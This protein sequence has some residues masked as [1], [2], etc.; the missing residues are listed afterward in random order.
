MLYGTCEEPYGCGGRIHR[1]WWLIGVHDP[2]IDQLVA[3]TPEPGE[4]HAKLPLALGL[5]PAA[6]VP[7]PIRIS[8]D[9]SAMAVGLRQ[10]RAVSRGKE[11]ARV[12]VSPRSK[13]LFVAVDGTAPRQ[14][15]YQLLAWYELP[16]PRVLIAHARACADPSTDACRDSLFALAAS[17]E[18]IDRRFARDAIQSLPVDAKLLRVAVAAVDARSPAAGVVLHVLAYADSG[19]LPSR[20][21]LVDFATKPGDAEERAHALMVL[22]RRKD[23][24]D[25]D[26]RRIAAVLAEPPAPGW[27]GPVLDGRI[28]NLLAARLT[29]QDA[30]WARPLLE[31]IP[32]KWPKNAEL[33]AS[34][35]KAL[36]KLGR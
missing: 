23:A 31:R 28:C 29:A 30:A 32:A 17:A 10:L 24:T 33:V 19:P 20:A 4:A 3:G 1:S 13:L 16:A 14:E 5:E 2:A 6:P 7:V 36:D 18:A 34:C 15:E 26:V 9:P 27:G 11:T 25:D 12:L 22:D 35:Q 21:V 8:R